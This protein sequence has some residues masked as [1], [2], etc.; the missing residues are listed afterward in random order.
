MATRRPLV[1]QHLERISGT[2]LDK[3][4]RI[5][6]EYVRKRH[7]IYALYRRDRLY[8]VGLA[9]NLRNRL[10]HHL[11][12]RH[13]GKWDRFSVYL[14]IGDSHLKELESLVLRIV[15]PTGNSQTGKFTKAEDLRRSL[16]KRIKEYHRREV[17]LLL[18]R[19]RSADEH[20][21]GKSL[22]AEDGRPLAGLVDRK[23]KLKSRY[24]GKWYSARLRRDGRIRYRGKLYDSPSGAGHAARK[25]ATNGWTFW[26]YERAPGDWV[27]LSELRRR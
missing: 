22:S 27:K 10:N 17:D 25:R 16:A 13:K 8:Y 14:T 2:A 5:I 24:K 26:T 18:N 21:S 12:D 4:Q 9:S 1:S 3:F 7:G 11:R 20:S 19:T 15:Q 23:Y 6:R